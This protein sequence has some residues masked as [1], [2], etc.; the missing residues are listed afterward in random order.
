MFQGW[1][2][3]IT[4]L[5]GCGKSTVAAALHEV[6]VEDWPD[7]VLLQM[8]ARRKEYFPKPEYSA[9]ERELAYKYFADEAANLAAEGTCVIMDGVAMKAEMRQ[10]ARKKMHK[11]AEIC[12]LCEVS[13]AMQREGSRPEGL[14]MADLYKKALRRKKTGEQVKGLGDVPGVDVEF[15]AD[16]QAELTIDNSRL[17]S[18][19]TVERALEFLREWLA[20]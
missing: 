20:E 8:D 13:V 1:V 15:E 5:P 14:V 2:V 4:G 11:F 19:E 18:K 7:L 3:W 10:Y 12:L 16:P 17:T 6:L 9:Q